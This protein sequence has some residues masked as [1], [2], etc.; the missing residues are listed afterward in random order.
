M[1]SLSQDNTKT[2]KVKAMLR[3]LK[4]FFSNTKKRS[5]ELELYSRV[6]AEIDQGEL[7]QGMLTKAFAKSNGDENIAKANYIELRVQSLKDEKLVK[8]QK[9]KVKEPTHN[10]TLRT[11][12][13]RDIKTISRHCE[14]KDCIRIIRTIKAFDYRVTI[15][16]PY[17]KSP[18]ETF[19]VKKSSGEMTSFVGTSSFI[20]F[21]KAE[22]LEG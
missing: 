11:P 4:S 5:E 19:K 9:L 6:K 22:F 21:I 13:P 12:S 2:T 18:H 15:Q 20:D 1:L 14:A 7:E 16:A 3:L 8:E 17:G 10:A